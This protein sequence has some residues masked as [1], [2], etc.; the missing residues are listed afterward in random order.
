MKFLRSKVHEQLKTL[1]E[2]KT[3]LYGF[4]G[5]WGWVFFRANPVFIYLASIIILLPA[6]GKQEKT[7]VPGPHRR[8]QGGG[9]TAQE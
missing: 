7:Q 6:G 5:F 2:I 4:L 3:H 8:G 1:T 9:E